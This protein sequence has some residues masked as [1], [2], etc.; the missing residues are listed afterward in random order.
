MPDM[1]ILMIAD[2][3]GR[4]GREAVLTSLPELR[5]CYNPDFIVANAE[6]AAGGLGL[7]P[8]IAKTFFN[9]GIDLLTLGNHVWDK[10]EIIEYLDSEARLLRPANLPAGVP[11]SGVYTLD[12]R[13]NKLTVINLLGRVFLDLADCPFKTADNVLEALN[14]GQKMILVDMHAEAT[15]EKVAMGYFLD[16][17]VSAVIGTHTHVSTTDFKI[18]PQGTGYVT[19]IGMTGPADSVI[20][21]KKELIIQKFCDLMPVK[22]EVANG[23]KQLEGVFL[24]LTPEGKAGK[25]ERVTRYLE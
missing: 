23:P 19:D 18:L 1:K 13:G 20:G 25:I 17:R 10:K 3:V 11:G 14:P 4:P 21:I 2:I 12:S 22:F 9:A 24:E 5:A 15:S 16:G 7:T 6:N 8:E